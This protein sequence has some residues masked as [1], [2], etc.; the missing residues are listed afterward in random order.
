MQ[1]MMKA[2][3]NGQHERAAKIHQA[4]LPLIKELFKNPNPV[5]VKYAM[6][7]VGFQIE[8]V[9]LPL[10]EMSEEEK[11][12]SIGCGKSLNKNDKA[13]CSNNSKKELF[14]W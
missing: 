3:E 6:S 8:K 10:V 11:K 1:E 9:R 14:G 7:K 5:P 4:L 12:D 2:F 13:Y